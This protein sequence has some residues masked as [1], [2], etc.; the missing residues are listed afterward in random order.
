MA[1]VAEPKGG[2]LHVDTL[3]AAAAAQLRPGKLQARAQGEVNPFQ[4]RCTAQVVRC[5]GRCAALGTARH[6][7]SSDACCTALANSAPLPSL[8]LRSH[9]DW[10]MT[11]Y[12][13]SYQPL[14]C[15]KAPALSR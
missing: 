1:G 12:I 8:S 7:T 5:V 11:V 13:L 10:F 15:S 2:W 14:R 9:T 4:T 6:C 3:L